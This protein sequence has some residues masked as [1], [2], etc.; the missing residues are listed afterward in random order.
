MLKDFDNQCHTIMQTLLERQNAAHVLDLS[1]NADF[2][3]SLQENANKWDVLQ[4][5][6]AKGYITI[7][8]NPVSH[9]LLQIHINKAGITYPTDAAEKKREKR[10]EMIR[11]VITTVIAV[12][13]LVLAGISLAA[14]LHLIQLPVS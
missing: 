14:Q 5:L 6:D 7:C 1:D 3:H 13:A 11:Y 8:Q 12:L 4:Y 9:K 2:F 10:V